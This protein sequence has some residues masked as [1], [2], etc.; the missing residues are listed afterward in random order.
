MKNRPFQAGSG[1]VFS[2]LFLFH[3]QM[4]KAVRFVENG[5]WERLNELLKEEDNSL[6]FP[7]HNGGYGQF[8][9]LKKNIF[10][11]KVSFFGRR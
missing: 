5:N 3:P 11:G 9:F 2:I 4:E 10:K 8:I 6:S 7:F 1:S